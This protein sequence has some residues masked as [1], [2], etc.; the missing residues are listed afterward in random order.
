MYL[1]SF[2]VDVSGYARPSLY[3]IISFV[4][5]AYFLHELKVQYMSNRTDI[6]CFL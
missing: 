1:H 2:G 3:Y 4:D 5:S 6:T